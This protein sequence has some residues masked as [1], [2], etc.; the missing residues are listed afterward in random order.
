MYNTLLLYL[1]NIWSCPWYQVLGTRHQVPGHLGGIQADSLPFVFAL[2]MASIYIIYIYIYNIYIYIY[3]QWRV[4]VPGNSHSPG[5]C[6]AEGCI[7]CETANHQHNNTWAKPTVS[8]RRNI[9]FCILAESMLS[10]PCFFL[11]EQSNHLTY[12]ALP[13][14]LKTWQ[15]LSFATCTP[16]IYT[17]ID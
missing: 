9:R 16:Q 12:K 10:K 5:M 1:I 6:K 15:L 11:L 2:F 14:K 7:R 13:Q 8:P 17:N 4:L 3:T